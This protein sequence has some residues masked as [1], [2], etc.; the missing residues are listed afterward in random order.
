MAGM[1]EANQYR[2]LLQGRLIMKHPCVYILANKPWGTLY[3]GV[4][5]NL[6]AR[7]FQHKNKLA[8][9]FSARYSLNRLVYFELFEDMYTAI[10]REKQLK[11]GP[12]RKKT[13]LITKSNPQWLDLY[14]TILA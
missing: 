8:N 7:I 6:P 9:G 5:S 13:A 2:S 1:D 4:T 3:V 12:R 11:A 10:A 14:N